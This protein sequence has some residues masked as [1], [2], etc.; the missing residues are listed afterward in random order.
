[1]KVKSCGV[2]A[3]AFSFAVFSAHAAPKRGGTATP[4]HAVATFESIGVYWAPGT[5]PGAAGCQIQYRVYNADTTIAAATPWKPGLAM[6]YDS[7]NSECRGSL[8][9]LAPGTAYEIQVGLP[10]QAFQPSIIASTWADTAAW[11]ATTVNVAGGSSRR[12]RRIGSRRP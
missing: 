6:W 1:M 11:P 5:N 4:P 7:R 12:S 2:A 3:L 8:V 9:Q 10:T